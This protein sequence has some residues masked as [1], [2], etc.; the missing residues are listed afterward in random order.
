MSI[1]SAIHYSSAVIDEAMRMHPAT[2]FILERLV[3]QN[4]VTLHGVHLPENTVVGVNAWVLHRNKD[5]FGEDA[6]SFRPER[7]IENDDLKIKEMKRNLFAVSPTIVYMET[8]FASD[9]NDT[10]FF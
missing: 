2:G 7:W 5:V 4:G 8:E 6:H 1:D 3:P 10:V 9:A